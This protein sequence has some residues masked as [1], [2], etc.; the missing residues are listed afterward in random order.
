LLVSHAHEKD[1]GA[2]ASCCRVNGARCGH[3][4][5][6]TTALS[7]GG[8]GFGV[9]LKKSRALFAVFVVFAICLTFGQLLTMVA[10][11]LT[12]LTRDLAKGFVPRFSP[13]LS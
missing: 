10:H 1:S 7:F 12:T 2:F 4:S 9:F 3:A 8:V 13:G 5:D 11:L 6:I